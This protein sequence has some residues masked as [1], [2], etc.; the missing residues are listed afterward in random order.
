MP[1]RAPRQRGHTGEGQARRVPLSTVRRPAM[2]VI[3]GTGIN[4]TGRSTGKRKTARHAKISGQFA[5]RLV[6][7]LRSPAYRVLSVSAHRVLARLEI[8]FAD[9]G[10]TDNGRLPVTFDDFE[11]YGIERHAIAPAIREC[12]ALGFVEI[13]QAGRAGNAEFRTPSLY[14]ITYRNCDTLLGD[15]T[16]EWREIETTEQALV[17]ARAARNPI[18]KQKSSAGKPTD[19]SAGKP[20]ENRPSPVRETHTTVP[21]GKPALHSISWDAPSKDSQPE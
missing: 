10:G 21:V 12:C 13:T 17:L 18:K 8:E 16:H 2:T 3:G 1:V 9:H 7:M 20:T 14:R 6:E 5:P 19:T 15:G 4:A 11:E